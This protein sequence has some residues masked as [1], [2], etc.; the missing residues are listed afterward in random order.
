M[1]SRK[2]RAEAAVDA[3][4]W[5]SLA[6]TFAPL[7]TGLQWE[8]FQIGNILCMPAVLLS[9]AKDIYSGRLA[10]EDK[11]APLGSKDTRLHAIGGEST[12]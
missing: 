12:K 6:A 2:N 3:T 4:A 1:L 7:A 5:P 10:P 9:G 8:V 11:N